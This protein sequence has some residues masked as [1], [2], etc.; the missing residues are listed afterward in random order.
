MRKSVDYYVMVRDWKG[1]RT[2]GEDGKP[3]DYQEQGAFS[4]LLASQLVLAARGAYPPMDAERLD[5]K[6]VPELRPSLEQDT[7]EVE[8]NKDKEGVA[9]V[10]PRNI[11]PVT[12]DWLLSVDAYIHD[13]PVNPKEDPQ[14]IQKFALQA[15]EVLYKNR[16]FDLNKALVTPRTGAEFW[17]ARERLWWL[18]RKYP[19][20][21][22]ASEAYKD[23]L[24]TFF[25]E[26]DYAAL[27]EARKYGDEHAIGD[28]KER[29]E[30]RRTVIEVSLGNIAG[31]AKNTYERAE[32][33]AAEADKLTNPEEAGKVLAEV[34]STY[35][36][37]GDI[38]YNLRT[39]IT[40]E[41]KD[42]ISR[43]KQALMNAVRAY[44]RAEA[45]DDCEK[46]LKEAEDK[47]RNAK[48]DDA[49]EKKKNIERLQEI[50]ET[51]VELE[52]KFF[53]IP[54][55]I[56]DF[57]SLY[58]TDTKGD[59]AA[60]YLGNAADL[61]F[62][63]SNWDLAIQLDRQ[64]VARFESDPKQRELVRKSASRISQ[65]YQKKGDIN[66]QIAALEEFIT[67]YEKDKT[68]SG[69]V[70][71]NYAAIADIYE[72]RGDRKSA[73]KL[74]N[75]IVDAFNKGGF[76]KSGGP[77]ATAAAQAQFRLMEPRYNAFMAM[78]IVENPKLAPAKRGIDMQNQVK[79]MLD[80]VVGAEKKTKNAQTGEMETARTGGM[81]EEY[82]NSVGGYNSQNWSY[83]AYLYRG[84]MLQY[85]ARAIYA[86]PEP[87]GLNDT[88]LEE[89][90]NILDA[91]GGQ[92]ENQAIK[93]LEAAIKDA[94][95][96]GAV[97][98]WVTDLRKAI[99][100][101][102]P[103]DYP[104]LKDEKRLTLDPVGTL[105]EPDK[106]LR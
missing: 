101:Y 102:K 104:L 65:T 82:A 44:Y 103:K 53:H 69:Q 89:Y 21:P 81:F 106:D 43:Q 30:I 91:Y 11:D 71:R 99:N 9:R 63:N 77:E 95:A 13:N 88:E 22:Q 56:A 40:P 17:S 16:Q 66:G 90:H 85:L 2:L 75:R 68:M 47:V 92:M 97:N 34:R 74:Y 105:T 35:K 45:W 36:R 38:F 67:H 18:I 8:A 31:D 12:V 10:T 76:E 80:I 46:V 100:Q 93:S 26:H 61:A 29:D 14:R 3:M 70:F 24:E 83:A 78:K 1:Q 73:D 96:K 84:K 52:Y 87:Q 59:K 51:R 41:Q 48:A 27:D 39:S 79:A 23:L 33:R 62:Y 72:G 49:V 54:E 20:S 58:D 55:A 37:A 64:I 7:A 19:T 28:A 4:A 15:A 98:Q 5:S 94:D 57:R 86:A 60:Y 50:I 6:E 32:K 42:Y 25:I